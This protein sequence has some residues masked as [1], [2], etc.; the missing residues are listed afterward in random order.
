MHEELLKVTNEL[1]TV[2][3]T[4]VPLLFGIEPPLL[5]CPA[6]EGGWP[7]VWGHPGPFCSV[8]CPRDSRIIR[9]GDNG[10]QPRF[11]FRISGEGPWAHLVCKSSQR[12]RLPASHENMLPFKAEDAKLRWG[13]PGSGGTGRSR[14]PLLTD[15][16]VWR[17]SGSP[18]SHLLNEALF[19][20]SHE[21][22]VG[23]I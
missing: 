19:G 21:A 1:Y 23:L 13:E 18:Y 2:S 17:S 20:G 6:L 14:G 22:R 12:F 5:L 3:L 11:C 4:P 10:S 16:G 7:A 9:V 15:C 8:L